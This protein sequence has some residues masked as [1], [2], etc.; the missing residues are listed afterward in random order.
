M[1]YN[2]SSGTMNLSVPYNTCDVLNG[3]LNS[4]HSV[5]LLLAYQVIGWKDP[6]DRLLLSQR[7]DHWKDEDKRLCLGNNTVSFSLYSQHNLFYV[8]V[9]IKLLLAYQVIGWKDPPGR[10][11]MN[12]RR[13]HWKDEDKRLC[14]GNN[15]VSFSLYSQHN[16]YYVKVIIKR[17]PVND[18]CFHSAN[19]SCLWLDICFWFFS[20][21]SLTST[22]PHLRCEIGLEEGGY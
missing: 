5:G 12:Q 20:P 9:I 19:F 10:L 13:D 4:T 15:T 22:W 21:F 17:D 2:V 16:L 14:F 8:K 11:L 7:R 18:L 3:V 1:T 6:P